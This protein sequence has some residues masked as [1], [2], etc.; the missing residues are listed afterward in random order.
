VKQD[1]RRAL[2][3]YRKA[4]MQGHEDAMYNVAFFYENGIG[5]KR[6]TKKAAGW[7]RAAAA[8]GLCDAQYSLG[9]LYEQGLNGRSNLRAALAWY[10]KATHC[11]DKRVSR[12]AL[13]AIKDLRK[14]KK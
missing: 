1:R 9:R 3:W 8:T 12:N 11:E 10:S 6:N 5:V 14:R 4:A 13:T 2:K 7:Y